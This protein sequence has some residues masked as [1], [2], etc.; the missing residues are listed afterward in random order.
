MNVAESKHVTALWYND[1]ST[2][3]E[4]HPQFHPECSLPIEQLSALL[5]ETRMKE[6][7]SCQLDKAGSRC[8]QPHRKGWL[9]LRKDGIKCL[10]GG[11]CA[12]KHFNASETFRAER[13]R[14][15]HEIAVHENLTALAE[16]LK[17]RE[18]TAARIA[19]ARERLKTYREG[20]KFWNDSLPSEV[21]VRLRD[22]FKASG[23]RARIEVEVQYVELEEDGKEKKEKITWRRREVGTVMGLNIWDGTPIPSL[24]MALHEAEAA[25]KE[26]D[27]RPEQKL[28]LLKK[29][30]A[31]LEQ[32]AHC[33]EAIERMQRSLGDFGASRNVALL[34]HLV[35][36][37]DR[38]RDIVTV[39]LQRSGEPPHPVRV[40]SLLNQIKQAVRKENGD[41][42]FRL[43]Y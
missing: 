15:I 13:N 31:A 18:A 19:K 20:V 26:A 5:A 37:E 11:D 21:V 29:W 40:Q 24:S 16:L 33:E 35:R 22:H 41:R 8:N 25:R 38:Q 14:L 4:H 39:L 28:A 32:L 17:D 7:L 27:L 6:T 30:R 1:L 3:K 12:N 23:E 34:C 42:N 43:A 2:L 9:A 36:N 10:I